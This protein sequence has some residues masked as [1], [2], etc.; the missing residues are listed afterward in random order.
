M[1]GPGAF[2]QHESGGCRECLL[3]AHKPGKRGYEVTSEPSGIQ[4]RPD[5]LDRRLGPS[6]VAAHET[7]PVAEPEA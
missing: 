3:R 2:E 7:C 6:G 4:K 5:T 1:H